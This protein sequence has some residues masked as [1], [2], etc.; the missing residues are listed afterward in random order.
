MTDS[1]GLYL[2]SRLVFTLYTL[3]FLL[4]LY[5]THSI[6][7]YLLFIISIIVSTSNPYVSVNFQEG[8]DLQLRI[9]SAQMA[10]SILSIITNVEFA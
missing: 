3:S 10:L 4:F 6:S 2:V 9:L 8:I 7:Q 1:F 5:L